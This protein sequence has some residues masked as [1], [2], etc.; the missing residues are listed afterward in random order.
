MNNVTVA[1]AGNPNVGKSTIFNA[2]TGLKQHT[3]NWAGKTVG[4]AKG[5]FKTENNNYTL[6]DIPGTYS[7]MSRSKEEEIARD[8]LLFGGVDIVLVVCDATT[9][10]R[11]LNLV[12]QIMEIHPKV[13]LCVNLM[14]EAKRKGI[15]VDLDVL[16]KELSIP[17]IGT[18]ARDKKSIKTVKE[19]LDRAVLDKAENPKTADISNIINPNYEFAEQFNFIKRAEEIARKSVKRKE[20]YDLLDRRLD[21]FF[22]GKFTGYFSMVL[23]LCL[24]LWITVWGAN[25]LSEGLSFL[26][27][28]A[29]NG[30]NHLLSYLGAS[31]KLQYVI[32]EGLLRVPFWV[33]AVM[34]PPMAIFFPLFTFLEDAG[35]LPRVA[36][37]LDKPFMKCKSCGKQALTMCM[38]FGCNAVGVTGC[39][40][41]DSKRERLLAMLTNSL[42]PCNGRFPMITTL[43]SVF[44][45]V[46][47]GREMSLIS[48]I[49]LTLFIVLSIL[50]TFFATNILS[51]TLLKG[52]TTAYTLE[53]PPFRKPQTGKIIIRSIMDRTLFVLGRALKTA[54]PA[55]MVLFLMANI[56]TGGESLLKI[57][58]DFLDPIGKLMGLDGVILLGFILG[59]PANEIVLPIILMIYLTATNLTQVPD[60]GAISEILL[61]NGW[62]VSTAFCTVI[63]SLFHWPC[64]T[65][66]LTVKKET[67]SFKWTAI[68]VLFPTLIGFLACV[69][70]NGICSIFYKFM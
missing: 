6:V 29:E 10:E 45:V 17:V 34:L 55:G 61:N 1:V 4:N 14:D 33:V 35:Y 32:T 69:L 52:E 30:I 40:I 56:T 3:G 2:L 15:E 18:V 60:I 48:G 51:K 66:V 8:F 5:H 24:I 68:S 49:F 20:N 12:F 41:I 50:V 46:F 64:A 23:F 31:E 21:R 7:L 13:V 25:Y 26:L 63:F 57:A 43:I 16:E 54:I 58:S 38:G 53:L 44:T 28:N 70:I 27:G 11:N 65:T 59:F 42:V 47:L 37:N 39:R 36:F 9:L 62:T 22:T 19:T 67:K